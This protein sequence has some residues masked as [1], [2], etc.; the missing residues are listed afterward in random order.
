MTVEIMVQLKINCYK[1]ATANYKLNFINSVINN[2][3]ELCDVMEV[4]KQSISQ[5]KVFWKTT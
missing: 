3:N 4:R 5:K 1:H 2:T